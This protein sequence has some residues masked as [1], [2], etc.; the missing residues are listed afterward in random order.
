M[1][2]APQHASV[3]LA[4]AGG[5]HEQLAPF[6]VTKEQVVWYLNNGR[7]VRSARRLLDDELTGQLR[8][9]ADTTFTD[10]K[11]VWHKRLAY[12]VER[13]ETRVPDGLLQH[14]IDRSFAPARA[15]VEPA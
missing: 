11:W 13:H 8:R 15:D 1:T 14:M 5:L 6:N 4:T 10:G 9:I 7:L 2:D 12:Y 3:D